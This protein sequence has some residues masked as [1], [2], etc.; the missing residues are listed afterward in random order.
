MAGVWCCA[1]DVCL[2]SGVIGRGHYSRPG[3]PQGGQ[4]ALDSI[5]RRPYLK[6]LESALDEMPGTGVLIGGGDLAEL[7]QGGK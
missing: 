7:I 5:A 2:G 4:G 3:P 1:G 6:D